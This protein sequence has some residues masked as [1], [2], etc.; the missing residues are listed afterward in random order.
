M[1][2]KGLAVLVLCVLSFS[3]VGG[4]PGTVANRPAAFVPN[5]DYSRVQV[6]SPNGAPVRIQIAPP[7]SVGTL[8]RVVGHYSGY[9]DDGEI[10]EGSITAPSS[11]IGG[12]ELLD[13]D[14]DIRFTNG[15]WAGTRPSGSSALATVLYRVEYLPAGP[16]E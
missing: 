7:G 4:S 15:L 1:R 2:A 3:L 14:L 11:S 12:R 9:F 8:H 10:G 13:F 16:I 5:W 6:Q